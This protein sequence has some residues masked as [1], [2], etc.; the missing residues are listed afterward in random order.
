MG[1]GARAG[2]GAATVGSLGA[3]QK[4]V[5]TTVHA[6]VVNV[7]DVERLWV[8]DSVAGESRWPVSCFCVSVFVAAVFVSA[9]VCCTWYDFGDASCCL[10]RRVLE[11][12]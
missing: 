6:C 9:T 10:F 1:A 12:G 7:L 4:G 8:W 2:T 5:L 11:A 3:V